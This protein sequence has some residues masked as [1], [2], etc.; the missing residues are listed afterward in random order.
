MKKFFGE[1]IGFQ[2]KISKE[3]GSNGF[4]VSAKLFELM[5]TYVTET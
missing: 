2:N 1:I 3:H 4:A 5:F